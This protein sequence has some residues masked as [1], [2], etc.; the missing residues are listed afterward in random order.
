LSAE[1][2]VELLQL[3]GVDVAVPAGEALGHQEHVVAVLLELGPLVE[4]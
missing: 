1:E 2:R 4:V 3:Q